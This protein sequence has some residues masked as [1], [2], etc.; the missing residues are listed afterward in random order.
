[1]KIADAKV[2]IV[3]ADGFEQSE[4]EVP[5]D[6]LREKG[7]TVHVATPDGK[8]VRGWDRKDWGRTAKA[9]LALADADPADYDVLVVPGGQIN[10]DLLRV[11]PDAVSLVKDFA[12]AGK[13]IAAICHGPWLLV[14][15]GLAKGRRMTSYGSVKTDVRNA[16][17]DWVDEE[18]V[19]SDGVV[20][21]RSPKDLPAF[22]ARIVEVVE[23]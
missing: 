22:V 9:D 15:A 18:V 10:P 19:E 14:E 8:D 13:P 21:S 4:L 11:N 12:A 3:S 23:R 17:A 2:L 5:R 6:D 7:A 16:G 20:T 1:M